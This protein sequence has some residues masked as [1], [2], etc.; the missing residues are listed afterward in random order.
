MN[1]LVEEYNNIHEAVLPLKIVS[2]KLLNLQSI[3]LFVF[4]EEDR[5]I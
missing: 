5:D 2:M 4:I 1:L 3:Y